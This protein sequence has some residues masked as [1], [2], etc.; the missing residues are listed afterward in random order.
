VPKLLGCYEAELHDAIQWVISFNFDR[1][2][3]IGCGE[4]YYA[5]GLALRL[6]SAQV[7][8]F[9]ADPIAR[10][11]CDDQARQNAMQEQV[12]IRG[13]CDVEELSA[14]LDDNTFVLC[15]CEGCE[16]ELLDPDRVPGLKQCVILVE[17]HEFVHPG[18]TATILSRFAPSHEIA[19]I[20]T[21]E[22]DSEA[23]PSLRRFRGADRHLAVS[24]LRS[25]S[26]E[27]AF[28]IPRT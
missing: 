16:L 25:V 26:M 20:T 4:G 27:W 9:D 18:L 24:E 22:R 13:A 14:L 23:Y 5:V 11:L 1:I 3:N 12:T 2:I 6:P 7:Y 28:M 17:L 8:A 21:E 19:C 15:D 10:R